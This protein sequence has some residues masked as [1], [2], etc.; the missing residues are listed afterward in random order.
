MSPQYR[1]RKTASILQLLRRKNQCE[2]VLE[3]PDMDSQSRLSRQ[4]YLASNSPRR[5]ELLSLLGLEYA[6]LPAQVNEIPFAAEDGVEYV[7]RM[8]QSKAAAASCTTK[9]NGVIITADTAVVDHDKDGKARILGKPADHIEAVE[10]LRSLRAHTHRVFTAI[11]LLL[12]PGGTI[13]SDLCVT[14]VPMRNYSDG[15][16]AAYVASGDPLDK[17]GAYAIQHP[18]FHPVDNMQGCYANVMG[19]PVC[20]LLRSLFS[21]GITPARNVPQACQAALGY[22][23]PVYQQ[24]LQEKAP[25]LLFG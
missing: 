2:S 7:Q 16:I 22:D 14:D 8:A 3:S 15:E 21:L 18:G 24:I 12:A 1:C 17:A 19:L 25:G 10:M 11:S 13:Q 20:H 5:K 4:I 9:V 23:C 6:I